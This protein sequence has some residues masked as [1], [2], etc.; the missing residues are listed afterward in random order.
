MRCQAITKN[1]KQCNH[2][3]KKNE[4][5]C[6]IHLKMKSI[7]FINSDEE[8]SKKIIR[9]QKY[10]RRYLQQKKNQLHGPFI[11][12]SRKW[13][14]DSDFVTYDSILN[15]HINDLF[16]YE[17]EN[18]LIYCFYIPSL[19][20]LIDTNKVNPYTQNPFY[21]SCIERFHQLVKKTDKQYET[22]VNEIPSNSIDILKLRCVEIFQKMDKL[23]V[24]TKINWFL[25]LSVNQLK[26]LY[27]KIEDIWNYRLGLTKEQKK[28]YTISGKAFE[29]R[30]YEIRYY[31]H[32]EELQTILLNEFEKF[33][34][35]GQSID[36]KTT[37]CYWILTGLTMVSYNAAE[38]YPHLVHSYI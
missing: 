32:K 28:K 6:G 19:Q 31:N 15:F 29:I 22:V 14:N 3:A 12:D 26:K 38:A 23:N 16:T 30:P 36:E 5:V 20:I 4:K 33:L 24:Y 35:E 11:L 9:I 17:D 1:N 8:Y 21:E 13:N 2:K 18:N 25:D 37:A 34:T 10:I 7:S 27:I